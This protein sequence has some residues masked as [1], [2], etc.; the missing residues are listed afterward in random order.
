MQPV[1]DRVDE[2]VALGVVE[3]PPK[4]VALAA[5]HRLVGNALLDIVAE[6]ILLIGLLHML[7]AFEHQRVIGFE[8][9]TEIAVEAWRAAGGGG[10][11]G[12]VA[13]EEFGEALAQ[14]VA[15]QRAAGQRQE[16]AAMLVHQRAQV[17][18]HQPLH[19][20]AALMR[21]RFDVGG[22]L[23]AGDAVIVTEQLGIRIG[24]PGA[25]RRSLRRGVEAAGAYRH[26]DGGL[27][28][29]NRLGQAGK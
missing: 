26:A 17:G 3:Q 23:D 10:R 2:A 20:V 27:E 25:C 18:A 15:A 8:Q 6:Q 28:I 1:A 24:R 29:V 19:M 14:G 4:S 11:I 7:N 22:V 9:V 21:N 12:D 13:A 5:Q 16:L